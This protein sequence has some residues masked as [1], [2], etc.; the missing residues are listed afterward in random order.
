M[1]DVQANF[2][3][4]IEEFFSEIDA[5]WSDYDP[6]ELVLHCRGELL[7]NDIPE[8][9]CLEFVDHVQWGEEKYAN[10]NLHVVRH[11]V[12]GKLFGLI[13]TSLPYGYDMYE[14]I[15][16]TLEMFEYLWIFEVKAV[17]ST[18]YERIGTAVKNEG[19]SK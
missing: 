19:L 13:D 4:E 11:K 2:P 5:D 8:D 18:S 10:V 15:Q 7:A 17:P 16:G 12:T 14:N 1:C 3:P 6:S 9:S